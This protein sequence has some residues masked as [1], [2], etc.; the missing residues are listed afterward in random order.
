[1]FVVFG[2]TGHTGQV[3]ANT[4]LEAGEPVRVV[5]R[6]PEAAAAWKARGAQTALASLD[7]ADAV[8]RALEGAQGVYL[9]A[10]P[11][12]QSDDV[13]GTVERRVRTVA[14]AARAA[15]VDHLVLL[16][17]VGAHLESG[18]GMIQGAH[19]AERVIRES[20][21]TA[22][23]VRA[24]YFQE[25][26]AGVLP[27]AREHGVLPSFIA[28][29]LRIPMVATADIG[30]V[31]A[32]AL[33]DPA[34]AGHVRTIALVGPADH[35]PEEVAEAVSEQLG[36][37]VALQA[38][39]LE[40]IPATITGMGAS[41]HVGALY[42]EMVAGLNAGRVTFADGETPIRGTHTLRDTLASLLS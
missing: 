39:P 3:V 33:R 32:R 31:A 24:C 23:F 2:A 30:A 15:G 5:V 7:D 22:T 38:V 13:P 21:L 17:S 25:N 11:S 1:M 40:A 12:L 29:G 42:Q 6:R 9:L 8:A 19:R 35:T 26:W 20:G 34:P 16:S 18:T 10:P 28:P 4:L 41:A 37:P 14:Q 27:V 36:R